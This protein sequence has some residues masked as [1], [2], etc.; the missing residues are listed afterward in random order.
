MIKEHSLSSVKEDFTSPQLKP[1][2]ILLLFIV[3]FGIIGLSL[4]FGLLEQNRTD[5]YLTAKE[6]IQ[7]IDQQ[8]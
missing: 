5:G 6:Q 3:I 1:E 4:C 2:F 7:R 8:I